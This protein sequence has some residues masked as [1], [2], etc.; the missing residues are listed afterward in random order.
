MVYPGFV[1]I[2]IHGS[3]G[4]DLMS[5]TSPGEVETWADSLALLGYETFYPTTITSDAANVS[6]GDGTPDHPMIPGFHLEGPFIA[7][8]YPVLRRHGAFP[9]PRRPRL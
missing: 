4:Q 5:M 8:E 2:H 6:P 3:Q 9:Q 1:D 7:P